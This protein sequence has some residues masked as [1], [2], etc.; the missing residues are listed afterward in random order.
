MLGRE[1]KSRT[2][3]PRQL[4]KRVAEEVISGLKG[5]TEVSR[6]YDIPVNTIN[7]WVIK[8]RNLILNKGTKEELPLYPMAKKKDNPETDLD[9]KVKALEEEIMQLRKKLAYSDLRGEALDTLINLAERTYGISVRK[10]SGAK[11]SKR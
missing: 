11:Q 6:D 5:V 3:Y 4:K 7:P 8:Y 9:K 2:I 1:S 10:N